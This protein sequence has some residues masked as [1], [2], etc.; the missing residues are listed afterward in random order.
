MP[1]GGD[2]YWANQ[3]YAAAST[4]V[5]FQWPVITASGTTIPYVPLQPITDPSGDYAIDRDAK[6]SPVEWL[7]RQVDDVCRLARAA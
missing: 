2:F 6:L 7:T 3:N 4:N 1:S 5:T